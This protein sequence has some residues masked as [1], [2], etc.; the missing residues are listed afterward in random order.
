MTWGYKTSPIN[1]TRNNQS[2]GC[3][4]PFLASERASILGCD[5]RVLVDYMAYQFS[6]TS[7]VLKNPDLLQIIFGYFD[8]CNLQCFL[9]HDSSSIQRRTRQSLLWAALTS[10]AF[11]E[12]AMNVLWHE[13]DS[14]LP[15][16]LV[17]PALRK[18]EEDDLDEED[19]GS[20]S[21]Y[22]SLSWFLK[23]TKHL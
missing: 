11:L 14:I 15:L 22:V 6:S 9:S 8:L 23:R 16:Y 12:P 7:L 20:E 1:R 4:L 10:R 5:S 17:L 18:E 13:M 3:L 19:Q 21:E 2:H